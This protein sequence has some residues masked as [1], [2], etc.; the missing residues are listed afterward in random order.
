MTWVPLVSKDESNLLHLG[1]GLRHS[2]AKQPVR[3]RVTPEFNQAPLYV[4]TGELISADDT[5][6][7]SL[8]AYWRKGPYLVGFE[9]LGTDVDS[10]V[11]G[12]PLLPR[13]SPQR[14][15]GRHR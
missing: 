12:E 13:L 9:Y 2:N 6:T 7:Y 10:A 8:E 3:A 5:I 11:S 1:L 4:D 15:L 14:F